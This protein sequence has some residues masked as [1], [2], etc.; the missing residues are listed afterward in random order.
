MDKDCGRRVIS[1]SVKYR[2]P[3]RICPLTTRGRLALDS[4][5][6]WGKAGRMTE[7]DILAALAPFNLKKM[8]D[9]VHV[10]D[11]LVQ[12]TL[13][14]KREDEAALE[15]LRREIEARLAG[16]PGVKNAAVLFTAHKAAP[17]PAPASAPVLPGV[18]SVIAVASGKGGVGKSTVA[19][20]LAIALAQRGLAVGLLDADIYGPSLPRMLGLNRKPE[21]RE[22]KMLPLD[23]WGVRCMSIGFLVEEETAMVWRGPMVMGALNQM[24]GQVEW[25]TLDVLVIDMPPGT[26]DA[27]LTLAQK[28]N[29]AGAV[30]V[31]TPQDIALIDARRGIKMFEQVRVPVLGLVENMSYFACPHCGERTDIFGHG[32]AQAE[33]ARIG[34]PFLGAVPLLLEIRE[35]GDAGAP[36]CASAPESA[37]A[38]AFRAVAEQVAAAL[39]QAR[40]AGPK[41]LF[42]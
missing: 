34:A 10:R 18:K 11:G 38:G 2:N 4:A 30:M 25:G 17:P 13:A 1:A 27:Q 32:G 33:A 37:A 7:Q 42:E 41:I 26:G 12:V 19:V 9:G 40:P 22:G 3:F 29:L 35:T 6:A 39:G 16:L 5:G 23:A 15:P 31:S 8:L 14:I 28:A 24:L 20:N 21:V 36:I